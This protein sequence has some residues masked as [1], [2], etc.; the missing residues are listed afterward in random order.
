MIKKKYI[1]NSLTFFRIFIVPFFIGAFF[2]PNLIMK[3]LSLFLFFIGAVSDFL[4]GFIARK[5]NIVS[6][7]GKIADP[8]ADKLLILSAFFILYIV[9]PNYVKFWMIMCIFLRDFAITIF[10]LYYKRRKASN[11]G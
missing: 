7:I 6:D 3:V 4:D 11:E 8:I 1:P 10:R 5:Y 2:S 9:Y